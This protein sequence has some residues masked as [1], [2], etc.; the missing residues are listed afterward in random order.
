MALWPNNRRLTNSKEAEGGGHNAGHG[1]PIEG[2]EPIHYT[3]EKRCEHML[4][5]SAQVLCTNFL[6][7][8][9]RYWRIEQLRNYDTLSQATF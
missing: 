2:K 3:R 7:C 5:R 1:R 8:W 6:L 9:A 4:E